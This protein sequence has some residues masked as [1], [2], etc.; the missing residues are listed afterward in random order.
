MKSNFKKIHIVLSLVIVSGFCNTACA[1]DNPYTLFNNNSSGYTQV[2]ANST[3]TSTA[4]SSTQY[5]QAANQVGTTQAYQPQ[6]VQFSQTNYV[7]QPDNPSKNST[8]PLLSGGLATAA[9]SGATNTDFTATNNILQTIANNTGSGNG[10]V[11][12]NSASLLDYFTQSYQG[13][14]FIPQVSGYE[15]LNTA[16]SDS[17]LAS[18]F[19][20]KLN[21]PV[22]LTPSSASE[23]SIEIPFLKTLNSGHNQNAASTAYWLPATDNAVANLTLSQTTMKALN[24]SVQA[25]ADTNWISNVQTASTPQ[26]LRTLVIEQ[27]VQNKL[28]YQALMQQRDQ[29]LMQA[30]ELSML[31]EL[32][33]TNT[34]TINDA[35]EAQ[36]VQQKHILRALQELSASHNGAR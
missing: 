35:S 8:K 6:P 10:T 36:A 14:S 31:Q 4:G 26:L 29:E 27:A 18:T 22:D 7:N 19:K 24:E 25:P 2:A 9:T 17:A 33:N 21:N 20:E 15:H 13:D 5:V 34:K 23:T 30:S 12:G 32:I 11:A 3:A 1:N 16:L 28:L